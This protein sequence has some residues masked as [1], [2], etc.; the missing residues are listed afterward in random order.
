MAFLFAAGNKLEVFIGQE[1]V[2]LVIVI[3]LF[4]VAT[5]REKYPKEY[6]IILGDIDYVN[7][8]V[9]LEHPILRN[10][11]LC[12]FLGSFLYY[13]A[14]NFHSFLDESIEQALICLA[15]ILLMVS[16]VLTTGRMA[17]I[18]RN[19]K[20]RQMVDV[21]SSIKTHGFRSFSTLRR[22]IVLTSNGF[23][24]MVVIGGVALYYPKVLGNLD[25]R[26]PLNN[27]L[28]RHLLPFGLQSES[29]FGLAVGL[30]AK[31]F[32]PDF[33]T[34]RPDNMVDVRKCVALLRENN[35]PIP[36]R[37]GSLPSIDFTHTHSHRFGDGHRTVT[38]WLFGRNP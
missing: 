7:S 19:P 3:V 22:T 35:L 21:K 15:G 34:N 11:K 29:E 6:R 10:D 28:S 31:S 23:G 25:T 27:L 38:D 13:R 30:A 33:D 26:G 9:I 20:L 1:L 14:L 17:V 4:G 16:A 2:V 24:R 5:L 37:Y 32:D 8:G 18:I 36:Y 12:A